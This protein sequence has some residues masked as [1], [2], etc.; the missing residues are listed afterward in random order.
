MALVSIVA[1]SSSVRV[2]RL[3][4]VQTGFRWHFATEQCDYVVK[5]T[6]DQQVIKLA[7]KVYNASPR[8]KGRRSL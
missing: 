7:T 2:R 4:K 8:S 3:L 6:Q 5:I 1:Y